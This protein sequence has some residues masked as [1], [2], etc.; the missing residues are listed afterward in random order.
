MNH[1]RRLLVFCS[2]SRTFSLRTP[3]CLLCT[4]WRNCI[5]NR[6]ARANVLMERD[7]FAFRRVSRKLGMLKTVKETCSGR[8]SLRS[9]QDLLICKSKNII[10]SLEELLSWIDGTWW[11]EY[12]DRYVDTNSSRILKSSEKIIIMQN[13]LIGF[14]VYTTQC[15]RSNSAMIDR[16]E[17]S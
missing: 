14:A 11:C 8:I 5:I 3:V 1:L 16:R 7:S 15:R 9:I 10:I 13:N 12:H 4:Q 2:I 17:E 6:Y